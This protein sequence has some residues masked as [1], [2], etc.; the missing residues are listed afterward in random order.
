[1]FY[2]NREQDIFLRKDL[3]TGGRENE[4][5]KAGLIGFKKLVLNRLEFILREDLVGLRGNVLK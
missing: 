5:Q 1:M 3:K 4:K 2:A